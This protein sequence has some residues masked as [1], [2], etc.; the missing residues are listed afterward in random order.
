MSRELGGKDW[1]AGV[2]WLSKVQKWITTRP[3]HAHVV[4]VAK[5][6]FKHLER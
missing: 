2:V 4:I 3:E 1:S 6:L 5:A